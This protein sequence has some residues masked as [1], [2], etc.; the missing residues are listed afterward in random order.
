[1]TE[2]GEVKKN[3]EIKKHDRNLVKTF[4]EKLGVEPL[5]AAL[6]ISRGH[7]NLSKVHEFFYPT[8]DSLHSPFLLKDIEKAVARILEAI[9]KREKIL[10]WGDYDVDGTTG[11]VVLRKAFHKL[12]VEVDYHIP[13]RVH[14]GYGLN[15][16]VLKKKKEEGIKV[17]IT[18]DTGSLAFEAAEWAQDNGICLIV[19]DHHIIDKDEIRNKAYALINPHQKDCPYPNKK[20]AGVGVAFK[21]AQALLERKGVSDRLFLAQL[22]ELVAVGTIADIMELTGENRSIVKFGLRRLKDTKNKGLKALIEVAGLKDKPDL[23]SYNIGFQIAPRINAAGRLKHAEIV[24]KLLE[25]DSDEEALEIAKILNETNR[26]RQELQNKMVADAF[27]I[28]DESIKTDSKIPFAIV[29]ANKN[30]HRG[31]VGLVASKIT[32]A[33]Y[34]PSFMISIEDGIGYGSA[35]SIEEFDVT[36]ALSK[37]SD[38]LINYGGHKQAAG[39][40]IHSDNIPI[41]EEILNSYATSILS[42]KNLTPQILIDALLSFKSISFKLW[43]EL[44]NFEPFGIGN[45]K[46]VFLTRSVKIN[47]KKVRDKCVKFTLADQ[48][49]KRLN[50]VFWSVDVSRNF[51]R[52]FYLAEGQIIDVVYELESNVWNG[53]SSFQLNIKDFK[54]SQNVW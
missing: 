41:L 38:I 43:Q 51:E 36:E 10:I 8:L 14:E 5:T 33:Y 30:W 6:L 1:M 13:H 44:K 48:Q 31:I 32:D 25:T 3:W 35:R 22:L 4:A 34:R 21:L 45:P 49:G 26:T 11:T 40:K 29:V 28:L 52:L 47:L 27:K 54:N 18:V 9:D 2:I 24:V 19:T 50:A 46:P 12:G 53:Y 17:I 20:I 16:E 37:A 39:F 23:S 15:L 42:T 7:D